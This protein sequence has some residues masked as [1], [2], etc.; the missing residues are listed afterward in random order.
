MFLLFNIGN[1]PGS[2]SPKPLSGPDKPRR[3]EVAQAEQ[4]EKK[5]DVDSAPGTKLFFINDKLE[6]ES[7]PEKTAKQIL[8]GKPL[9][10]YNEDELDIAL[11]LDGLNRAKAGFNNAVKGTKKEAVKPE[12]F[13]VPEGVTLT[14][15]ELKALQSGKPIPKEL[16]EKITLSAL[17]KDDVTKPQKGKN[18]SW[19]NEMYQDGKT[20]PFTV[21]DK[22]EQST[23]I[24][25]PVGF[26]T[27]KSQ[28]IDP[29]SVKTIYFKDPKSGEIKKGVYFEVNEPAGPKG[30]GGKNG[31]IMEAPNP[32]VI[33]DTDGKKSYFINVDESRKNIIREL[34]VQPGQIGV[35]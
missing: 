18:P 7:V 10:N 19:R 2:D 26:Q 13:Y 4:P 33:I 23:R 1:V 16:Q 31:V 25:L 6:L 22:N 30:P 34:P 24:G 27:N 14:P 20:F 8:E 17:T 21:L 11:M 29:K 5:P 3:I 15:D 9:D 28:S 35:G 32:L 12:G